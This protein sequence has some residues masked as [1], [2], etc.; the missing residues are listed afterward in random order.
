MT[1][2]VNKIHDWIFSILILFFL[3]LPREVE[4]SDNHTFFLS[5]PEQHYVSN[6]FTHLSIFNCIARLVTSQ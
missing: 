5:A 1:D 3:N 6:F 2:L 4:F